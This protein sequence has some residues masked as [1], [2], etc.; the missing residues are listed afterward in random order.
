[1]KLTKEYLNSILEYRDGE[2]YWKKDCIS[3]SGRKHIIAGQLAGCLH[4]AK[5]YRF[6]T[7]DKKCYREHRI[8]WIMFYDN[9]PSKMQID[10]INRIKNDNRIENLRIVN[11]SCNNLNKNSSNIKYVKNKKGI[12][13]L[14]NVKHDG[15]TISKT[16]DTKKEADIWVN[17]KKS[18]IF[19]DK[20][21]TWPI[22][23][24]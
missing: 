20:G 24:I 23:M 21:L 11:Q 2:L 1:M 17:E 3:G 4:K 14:A 19:Q 12:S 7:I 5:G 15:K 13:F 18:E 10:H 22:T 8:I 6:I 16:F 9:I